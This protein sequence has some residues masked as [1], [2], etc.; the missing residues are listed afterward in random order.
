LARRQAPHTGKESITRLSA[1][2]G[3]LKRADTAS[4]STCDAREQAHV[5]IDAPPQA[6]FALLVEDRTDFSKNDEV[7]FRERV[8]NQPMGVGY[9]YKS[10]FLHRRH[11]CVMHLRVSAFESPW[12]VEDAYFHRCEVAKRS[13]RGSLRYELMPNGDGTTLIATRHQRV[14]GLLG[15]LSGVLGSCSTLKPKLELLASRV[16]ARST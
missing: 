2:L 11:R 14:S 1:E 6:V 7:C 16:E 10:T 9:S 8:G 12:V 15:W 13:V 4:D 5:E 3:P